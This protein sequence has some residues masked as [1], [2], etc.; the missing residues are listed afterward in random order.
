M[1]PET[2]RAD[3]SLEDLTK[4][5]LETSLVQQVSTIDRS[6]LDEVA[7]RR[8]SRNAASVTRNK[9]QLRLLLGIGMP[10]LKPLVTYTIVWS[11]WTLYDN[12]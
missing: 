11:N 7:G 4:H 8:S 12:R 3:P 6:R 10:C 2:Q 9:S 5:K 1:Y